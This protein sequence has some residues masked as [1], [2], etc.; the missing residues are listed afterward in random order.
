M[1]NLDFSNAKQG[2]DMGSPQLNGQPSFVAFQQADAGLSST[3]W[4]WL[5]PGG[6][7]IDLEGTG[8]SY[9]AEGHAY[10]GTV[11]TIKI[12]LGN[13]DSTS[14]DI[15]ITGLNADAIPLDENPESFWNILA[16]DDTITGGTKANAGGAFF[17][18]AGDGLYAPIGNNK[19]GNDL[20]NIN[21]VRTYAYGDVFE[22]IEDKASSV[23]TFTGGNDTITGTVT[24]EM[25]SIHG[26]VWDVYGNVRV[27]GGHDTLVLRSTSA[28]SAIVGDVTNMRGS[29]QGQAIVQGGNDTL[30]AGEGVTGVMVGNVMNQNNYSYLR[31]GHD[32]IAGSDMR[33]TLVGD[34]YNGKDSLRGGSDTIYGYGGD[35]LIVGDVFDAGRI[36]VG[37]NDT[38]LGGEG[39][40]TI[41]GEFLYV[42]NTNVSGG[43]DRLYGEGGNDYISGQTG[44]DFIDGGSGDDQMLGGTGNDT[45]VVDSYL[46]IVTEKAGEGVDTVQTTLNALALADEVENLTFI[47]K[48]RFEGRGNFESNRITGGNDDDIFYMDG[49]GNDTIIGLGGTDT[50]YFRDL[51]AAIINLATNVN[52]GSAT[53]DRFSSIERIFGS[54]TGGDNLTGGNARVIFFGYGGNDLLKGG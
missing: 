53:G 22:V 44:N 37:G 50:L 19:G 1:A 20:I 13:N 28:G 2:A 9:D 35:D 30:L 49:Q 17:R 39:N 15:V 10:G 26:D 54:D 38:I 24:T 32:T 33:Q 14:P 43:N 25:Q 23:I 34:V 45:F 40:D 21:D 3:H 16:G 31:G 12:D 41:F 42:T 27:I 51:G 29:F 7:D 47:G 11:N 18:I 4:S 48:G 6:H 46:D 36:V 52:G 8:F 5:T